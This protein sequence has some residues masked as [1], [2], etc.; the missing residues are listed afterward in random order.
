M[1]YRVRMEPSSYLE[2]FVNLGW[3]SYPMPD[4]FESHQPLAASGIASTRETVM[5]LTQ[6][7]RSHFS[8]MEPL[9]NK[10]D[11]KR[12]LNDLMNGS[13]NGLN[14]FSGTGRQGTLREG[15]TL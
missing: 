10:N 3:L 7:G 2:Q 13:K 1:S 9:M 4:L 6:K 5:L 11:Y 15:A 14:S 8:E 12:L